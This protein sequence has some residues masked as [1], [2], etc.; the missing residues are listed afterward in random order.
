MFELERLNEH[1]N[2]AKHLVQNYSNQ[3]LKCQLL[4]CQIAYV[5][6]RVMMPRRWVG[7]S[8]PLLDT[9]STAEDGGII[10]IY[11]PRVCI[12]ASIY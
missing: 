4:M 2:R 11:G 3:K 8:A 1:P 6:H 7:G 10:I 9:G 12:F 5:A